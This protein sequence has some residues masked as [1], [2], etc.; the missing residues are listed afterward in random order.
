MMS[1]EE[2]HLVLLKF[3]HFKHHS[4]KSSLTVG[5]SV[6]KRILFHFTVKKGR[7]KLSRFVFFNG[8]FLS[9]INKQPVIKTW[10]CQLDKIRSFLCMVCIT[11]DSHYLW[12][13]LYVK[14]TEVQ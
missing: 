6:S 8:A 2:Y 14:H 9:Y 11:F 7:V 1:K 12:R 3:E 5:S 4:S 10:L 13:A